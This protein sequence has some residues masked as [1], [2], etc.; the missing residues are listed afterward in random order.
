MVKL[1]PPAPSWRPTGA[2]LGVYLVVSN[3]STPVSSPT[4]FVPLLCRLAVLHC[5][6]S[7][8]VRE[9]GSQGRYTV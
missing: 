6:G 2:V 1:S 3:T 4:L 9:N 8:V 7:K 5:F